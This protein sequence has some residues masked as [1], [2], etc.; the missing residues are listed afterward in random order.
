MI[1]LLIGI[2]IGIVMGYMA[3]ALHSDGDLVVDDSDFNT[4]KWTL[5]VKGNPE[6]ISTHRS[7][8]FKIKKQ[9]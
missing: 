1:Y 7:A 2:V 4:T 5:I 6:E 8:V 9:R 3:A